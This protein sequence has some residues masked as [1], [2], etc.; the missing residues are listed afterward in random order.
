MS[1]I[2][3]HRSVEYSRSPPSYALAIL[4]IFS[5]IFGSYRYRNTRN[6][7]HT[8][9]EAEKAASHIISSISYCIT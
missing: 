7:R 4:S 5:R 2:C 1:P 9:A 8:T 3:H 6:L